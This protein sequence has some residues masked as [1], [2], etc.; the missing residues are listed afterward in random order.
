[1]TSLAI[2]LGGTHLRLALGDGR[3]AWEHQRRLPR[4]PDT[5]AGGIVATI[6]ET[7]RQWRTAPEAW[8]GIG[9]SVAGLVDADGLVRRAENLNWHE[10][11]LGRAL[12]DAFGRPVAVDTDV[13]CGARYEAAEGQAKDVPAAL[14][15]SVG[16]GIGHALIFGGKVWRGAAG[17]ANAF[18]HIVIAPNGPPCYCGGAGCL[19]LIAGG[20]VQAEPNPPAGAL[21]ALAYAIGTAT[22]LVEPAAVV[23]SG[24]ALAQPW[25]DAAA[26]AKAV[27]DTC[28][29]GVAR[30]A[31]VLSDVDDANLRGAALLL[32]K[33]P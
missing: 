3:G 22:T 7:A 31:I 2:D 29:P 8:A 6:A 25:F 4:P 26:L 20:K 33:S 11:P 24:G 32:E 30:P 10:V 5:D 9:V 27:A 13:F 17:N 28:Y 12:A 16:T 15:I 19:C 18:G 14:Y 23:L 21:A 1:M